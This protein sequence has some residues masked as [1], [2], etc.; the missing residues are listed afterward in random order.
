MKFNKK[1]VAF[2][3]VLIVVL[4]FSVFGTLQVFAHDEMLDATYCQAA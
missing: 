2:I 4:N 1:I 3:M